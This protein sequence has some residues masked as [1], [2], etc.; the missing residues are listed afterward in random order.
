MERGKGSTLTPLAEKLVWAGHRISARLTPLLES[1]ASELEVEIGRVLVSD[2][3]ILRIHSTHGFA[4]EKLLE[5]LSA[6]EVAV[7]RK[8]VGSQ[9]AVASLNEGACDLAGLH[10]PEGEFESRAIDHYVRWFDLSESRIIHIATRRQGMMI[11]PGN[12]LKIYDVRDLARH[13]VRFINRQR[14]SGTRFLFDCLL[15]RMGVDGSRVAGY[16]QGE[17]THA[18]VAAYVASGMADAGF[19]IETPA[20][21]FKLDFQPMVR[22]R[23]FLMCNQASLST[24]PIQAVLSVLR[25]DAYREY[26]NDLPGYAAARC[27]EV[28]TLQAAFPDYAFTEKPVARRAA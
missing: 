21:R 15:E 3:A 27:G 26:V 11:A 22:E 20:R 8:Y 24:S 18:A 7:E 9:E 17:Y 5:T 14:G 6:G 13:G 19:G 16:E 2:R 23:Y 25:S 1:L 28:D 4:V 12:P 10:V